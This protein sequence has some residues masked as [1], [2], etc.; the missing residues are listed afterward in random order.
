M[1]DG[2]VGDYTG[3]RTK[4]D[5]LGFAA[6]MSGP[7]VSRITSPRELDDLV[8]KHEVVFMLMPG[9]NADEAPHLEAELS[10]T[11]HAIATRK[12]DIMV[13]AQWT[14]TTLPTLEGLT[15]SRLPRIVKVER[16]GVTAETAPTEETELEVEEWIMDN[17][18]ALLPELASHNFRDLTNNGRLTVISCIDPTNEFQRGA[19][20][21]SMRRLAHPHATPL[22]P[23]LQT[24]YSFAWLNGVRWAK[25]VKQFHIDSDSEL[26]RVVV[27]D[28]PGRRFWEDKEVDEEDEIETFLGDIVEGKIPAQR[29]DGIGALPGKVWISIKKWF[30]WSVGVPLVFIGGWLFICCYP[31]YPPKELR[32][33]K[34]EGESVE[35]DRSEA[36]GETKKDA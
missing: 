14:G 28:G 11:L 8:V 9:D 25:F 35:G 31:E 2:Q 26:P 4:E 22:S 23:E 20:L 33:K 18:F 15:G 19:F 24:R 30:P 17:R 1:R 6:R 5:F 12:Q 13:F 7:T 29:E 32:K 10:E 16:E 21:D 27:L 36:S 3:G 34:E